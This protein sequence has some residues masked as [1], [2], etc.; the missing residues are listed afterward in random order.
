MMQAFSGLMMM[1]GREGDPPFRVGL[2][3]V[4]FGTGMW[5]AI[6]VLAG[7]AQRQATGQGCVVDASLFETALAWMGIAFASFQL[8]GEMPH[9]H[10]TGSVRLVPFEAFET[11]DGPL[12]VAAGNDRLFASLATCLGRPEW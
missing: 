4:D 1:S 6:G 5:S 10:P 12:V 2:P 11:Q 7:R 3:V 9:R 8:T